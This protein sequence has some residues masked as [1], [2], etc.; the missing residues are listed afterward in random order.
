MFSVLR[1]VSEDA[2]YILDS[3][4]VKLSKSSSYDA[5]ERKYFFAPHRNNFS[6]RKTSLEM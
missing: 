2:A 3:K 1:N 6:V 4:K 5:V